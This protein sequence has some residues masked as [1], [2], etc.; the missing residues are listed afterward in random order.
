MNHSGTP[1]VSLGDLQEEEPVMV[2]R[3]GISLALVLALMAPSVAL[4]KPKPRP[5]PPPPPDSAAD[6]TLSVDAPDTD[7]YLVLTMIV[8]EVRCATT[9]QRIDV[10][11]QLT[12]DGVLVSPVLP[13]GSETRTCTNASACNVVYDIFSLDSHPVPIPGDQLYCVTARGV[14]GG[15]VLGPASGCEEEPLL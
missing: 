7:G 1:R 8:G 12:R 9:K 10:S 13:A 15:T 3:V 5:L 14:V 4:A 11:G 6:C 2:T